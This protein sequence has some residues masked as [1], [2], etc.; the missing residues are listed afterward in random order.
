MIS[1]R[2]L[3][4]G[5]AIFPTIVLRHSRSRCVRPPD[6]DFL[7]LVSLQRLHATK[8]PVAAVYLPTSSKTFPPGS[9]FRCRALQALFLCCQDCNRL[10]LLFSGRASIAKCPSLFCLPRNTSQ[11]PAFSSLTSPPSKS[12]FV[13][14]TTTRLTTVDEDKQDERNK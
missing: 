11:R 4:L 10:T 2:G 5:L 1:L 9:S 13:L 3:M 12:S 14:T 6:P 7:L 8:R